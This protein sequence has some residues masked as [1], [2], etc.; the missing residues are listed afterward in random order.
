MTT[1]G[2]ALDAE[3]V[4][5]LDTLQHKIRSKR[6]EATFSSRAA[7]DG[8][9]FLNVHSSAENDFDILELVAEQTVDF[10][11]RTH[12]VVHVFACAMTPQQTDS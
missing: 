12:K 10:L 9:V 4:A 8:R 11:I 7:P 5:L 6:P 2:E 1:H 3:V